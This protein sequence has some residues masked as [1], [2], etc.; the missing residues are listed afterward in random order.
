MCPVFF[1]VVPPSV[2][3]SVHVFIN[4]CLSYVSFFF[5]RGTCEDTKSTKLLTCSQIFTNVPQRTRHT[6]QI[7]YC[8]GHGGGEGRARVCFVL[9]VLRDGRRRDGSALSH[10]LEESVWYF[11]LYQTPRGPFGSLLKLLKRSKK[12]YPQ[13]KPRKSLHG[14]RIH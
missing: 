6:S 1:I 9:N 11:S 2:P 5:F 14:S 13:R 8:T 10:T 3:S 12:F 4:F 7:P